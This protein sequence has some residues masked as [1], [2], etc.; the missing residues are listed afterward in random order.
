MDKKTIKCIRRAYG[1]TRGELA[2][3]LGVD[4][5]TVSRWEA[6]VYKVTRPMQQRMKETLNLTEEDLEHVQLVIMQ[7]DI[8]AQRFSEKSINRKGV[9]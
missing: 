6:G 2:E 5:S 4:S 7:Q 9:N 1:Y 3:L 8:L